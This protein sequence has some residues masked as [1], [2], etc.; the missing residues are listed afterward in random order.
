[1][2]VVS[3]YREA[4]LKLFPTQIKLPAWIR[5]LALKMALS[6]L[7]IEVKDVKILDTTFSL[8]RLMR[9]PL[10][11]HLEPALDPRAILPRIQ[12]AAMI[13]GVEIVEWMYIAHAD[14]AVMTARISEYNTAGSQMIGG[15]GD[16]YIPGV[17]VE[18]ILYQSITASDVSRQGYA[19]AITPRGNFSVPRL[20]KATGVFKDLLTWGSMSWLGSIQWIG[21]LL[22]WKELASTP[23]RGVVGFFM[24]SRG[25]TAPHFFVQQ[26]SR[27]ALTVTVRQ[28]FESNDRQTI[29]INFRDSTDYTRKL[30]SK[31][32]DVNAGQVQVTYTVS[33]FPY[34]P[35]L[36]A[37]IQPED[38]VQTKLNEYVV[39]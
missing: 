12:E 19:V 37:E 1:V 35:P 20:G 11:P 3:E 15:N 24:D 38:N 6:N 17:A 10:L 8:R 25:N 39:S 23:I 31:Q 16:P 34:V 9:S 2:L 33:A 14:L 4:T 27:P 30:G 21:N 28:V 7:R 29:T 22:K 5:P 18:D 13:D 36:I 26:P 32:I